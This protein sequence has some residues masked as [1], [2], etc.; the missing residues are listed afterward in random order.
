MSSK[1]AHTAPFLKRHPSNKTVKGFFKTGHRSMGYLEDPKQS[2]PHDTHKT[3]LSPPTLSSLSSTATFKVMYSFNDPSSGKHHAS[4]GSPNA[5]AENPSK[6]S[7]SSSKSLTLETRP[8]LSRTNK[9]KPETPFRIYPSSR[10]AS[11]TCE[12][13]FTFNTSEMLEGEVPR[14]KPIHTS[15]KKN[16]HAIFERRRFNE[17]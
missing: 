17:H 3:V 12:W 8:L 11:P 13:C 16:D 7:E 9:K 1:T 4:Q 6:V 2:G 10:W 14:S 5:S 15:Q